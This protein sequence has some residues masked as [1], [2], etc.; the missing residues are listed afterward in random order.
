VFGVLGID[1][2][3]CSAFISVGWA[4]LQ[5][6]VQASRHRIS[7]EILAM[8][9]HLICFSSINTNENNP[10]CLPLVLGFHFYEYHFSALGKRSLIWLL[11]VCLLLSLADAQGILLRY[12]G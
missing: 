6:M 9:G 5:Q 11:P 1:Q 3:C 7:W 12:W 10:R 4:V 2:I 8:F